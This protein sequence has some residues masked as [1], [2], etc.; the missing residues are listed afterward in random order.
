MFLNWPASCCLLVNYPKTHFRVV[1]FDSQCEFQDR[2][3]GRLIGSARMVNGLYYFD[4]DLSSNK[5]TQGYGCSI[6]SL[7]ARE[8]IMLW[9][10]RLGHPSFSYLKHLFRNL[11]KNL[12]CSSFQ[13][14]SCYLSKSHRTTYLT[15][16]YRASKPFYLIH[17]DVGFLQGYHH[18]WC[19]VVCNF[20]R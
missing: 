5:T 3:L 13:C 12:D 16:P 18:D 6:S 15:K 7:S 14:E 10:F 1:F 19:K 9:H 20:Y 17:S 11:F 4:D 8:Q 2:N